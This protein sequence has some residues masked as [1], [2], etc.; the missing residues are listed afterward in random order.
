MNLNEVLN[1]IAEGHFSDADLRRINE[2]IIA[3]IK[4]NRRV[5]AAVAK[6][7][8][9]VGMQVRVNHPQLAG[10]VLEIMSI[11]RTKASLRAISN[12]RTYNVPLSLIEASVNY[13]PIFSAG[14]PE[15]DKVY[16]EW[17][18]KVESS[19]FYPA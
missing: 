18:S 19:E 3:R 17:L 10:Q 13:T 6:A 7:E 4:A 12:G 5:G 16:T 2:V 9:S 1:R 15:F 14:G 8:L 11:K